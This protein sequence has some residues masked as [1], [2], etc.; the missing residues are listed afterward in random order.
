MVGLASGHFGYRLGNNKLSAYLSKREKVIEIVKRGLEQLPGYDRQRGFATLLG[1]QII[2]EVLVARQGSN[3]N[4]CHCCECEKLG[5]AWDKQEGIA[6]V[7]TAIL[8]ESG[9]PTTLREVAEEYL[10]SF[11]RVNSSLEVPNFGGR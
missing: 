1:D 6:S 11:F 5:I 4:D 10:L 2:D 8:S 7:A 3:Y 9:M